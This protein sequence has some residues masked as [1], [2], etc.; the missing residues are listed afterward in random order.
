[1]D[2]IKKLL[3]RLTLGLVAFVVIVL[4]HSFGG[5]AIPAS[6]LLRVSFTTV[7]LWLYL[8]NVSGKLGPDSELIMPQRLHRF[9]ARG[10]RRWPPSRQQRDSDQQPCRSKQRQRVSWPHLVEH[11]LN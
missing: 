2:L 5:F 10:P 3:Y 7:G 1:M 9:Q 8:L 4:F 6:I 11:R